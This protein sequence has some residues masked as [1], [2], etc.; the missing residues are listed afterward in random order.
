MPTVVTRHGIETNVVV[1]RSRRDRRSSSGVRGA[2]PR[3]G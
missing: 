1:H 3:S 2:P